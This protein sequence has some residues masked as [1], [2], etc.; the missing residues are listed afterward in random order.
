M[1]R[2]R[3]LCMT[4]QVLIFCPKCLGF[5]KNK[6]PEHEMRGIKENQSRLLLWTTKKP[7]KIFENAVKIPGIRTSCKYDFIIIN[8][9][10]L[11]MSKLFLQRIQDHLHTDI[12]RL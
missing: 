1:L 11:D 9:E 7:K 4:K 3:T 2:C 5:Y 6:N 10:I 8:K 12:I